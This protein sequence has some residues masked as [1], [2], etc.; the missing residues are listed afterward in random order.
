[1]NRRALVSAGQA[2]YSQNNKGIAAPEDLK[3]EDPADVYGRLHDEH[4]GG[5]LNQA[6]RI[7][8]FA[9]LECSASRPCL[10]SLLI[11]SGRDG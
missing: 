6:R 10:Y 2:R 8:R 5:E 9:D 3:A 1:M 7:F 11:A 4:D